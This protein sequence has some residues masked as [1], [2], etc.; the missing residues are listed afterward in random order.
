MDLVSPIRR[1]LPPDAIVA[2]DVTR[3]TYILMGELPLEQ[4]RS[5]LHP[6]GSVAMGYALPAALGAKVAFPD[7]PVLTVVGD[8]GFQMSA[9]ELASAVQERLPVV[10]LLVNDDCLT[11]IKATQQRRYEERYIG[12]DLRN[13]DFGALARAFGVRYWRPDSEEGLERDLREALAAG[14]VGLVEVRP[15]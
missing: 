1:A 15:G 2:A 3:L 5:W 4:P 11:L 12:V 14:E 7:R 10:I 6:A 13:P 9:L 8:G